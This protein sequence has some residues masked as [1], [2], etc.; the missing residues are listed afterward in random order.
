VRDIIPNITKKSFSLKGEEKVSKAIKRFSA[1]EKVIFTVLVGIFVLSA[2]ALLS[3]VNQAFMVEVP[4]PGGTLREGVI[5]TP[6]FI[7]PLLALRDV[8]RD[9]S[10]LVYSGLLRSNGKGEL[11]GD[12]AKS[13]TI[14][15]DGL[16][17]TFI[18][19]DNATFHDGAPVTADDIEFTIHKAQDG[20]LKSPRRANWEGVTVEKVNE[21]QVKFILKKPYSPFIENTTMGI[22]PK[23]IWNNVAADEFSFSNYNIDPVGAGPFKIDKIQRDSGGLPSSYELH[24][25][26]E[27]TGNV[28]HI[29]H[30]IIKFYPNEKALLEG[31]KKGEIESLNS[32]SPQEAE[33]LKKTGARIERTPL[34]RVFG[35]FLNQNQAPVFINAEV[36]AALNMSLNKQRIVEEGLF[37]YGTTINDPIPPGLLAE[38]TTTKNASFDPEAAKALLAKNG[39]KPN[40]DGIL[41]K[42]TTKETSL[43]QFS[44]ITSNA[45]ELKRAAEI[46][47]EG[48]ESLGA[49]VDIKLFDIGDLNQNVIRPRKYDALLFGEIIGRDLDLFAFWHS[50]QRNDP[51]LNIA[52]Y[53]N[54]KVDKLLEEARTVSDRNTRIAKYTEF[55]ETIEKET[56]AIFMYAPDFIYVV[57]PKLKGFTLGQITTPDNRFENISEWYINTD[58]VWKIFVGQSN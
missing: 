50:S 43:L 28:P 51:G 26:D 13:Y 6:R 29:D 47:K 24:S 38:S 40:K 36:R 45:P 35:L 48:W 34:P 37:G 23:H 18:L 58:K 2:L 31:Y 19:K 30:V 15:A 7:N 52:V 10:S 46:A 4:A 42:K 54:A 33:I 17:Y 25:F 20:I 5:G 1:T 3:N 16:T 49:K 57:P 14:S 55:K 44:I 39:W 32:I 21:K 11:V 22:L 9:L 41:E 53:V 56:P 8:D 27:Y 12:L